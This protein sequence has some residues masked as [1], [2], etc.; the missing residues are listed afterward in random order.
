MKPYRGDS[1]VYCEITPL[2]STTPLLPR[3]SSSTSSL[4]RYFRRNLVKS[5]TSAFTDTARSTRQFQARSLG[6]NLPPSWLCHGRLIRLNHI[7]IVEPIKRHGVSHPIDVQIRRG[8]GGLE[9]ATGLLQKIRL[10]MPSQES[11]SRIESG[12]TP[13]QSETVS[14]MIALCISGATDSRTLSLLCAVRLKVGHLTRS[15]ILEIGGDTRANV[16]RTGM[17][18]DCNTDDSA[19]RSVG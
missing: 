17:G 4:D 1:S 9:F 15:R 13:T 3:L 6:L 2:I 11:R 18:K 8:E 16:E 5:T 12:G 14:S 19:H 7:C 10:G